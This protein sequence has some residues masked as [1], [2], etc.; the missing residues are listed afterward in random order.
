MVAMQGGTEVG[1]SVARSREHLSRR[2][3]QRIRHLRDPVSAEL[4]PDA[5]KAAYARWADK[6]PER[7]GWRL[8]V[9]TEQPVVSTGEHVVVFHAAEA[10][11]GHD[12]YVMGP[13][14]VHGES[15]D[16]HPTTPPATEYELAPLDYDGKVL[17]GPAT[18]VNFEPTRYT[19]DEPGIHVV[20]WE[21]GN[22]RSNELRIDV[23]G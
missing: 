1:R 8:T 16:G 9:F 5:A 10:T 11:T 13:K 15:V 4:D 23:R 14:P 22:L 7:D 19:F 21:I 20:T 18:D 3:V 6:G 2:Q 17:T 12:V